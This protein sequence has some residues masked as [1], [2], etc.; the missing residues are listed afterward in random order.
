MKIFIVE[1]DH[2]HGTELWAASSQFVA[3]AIVKSVKPAIFKEREGDDEEDIWTLWKALEDWT[4][5]SGGSEYFRI[6][7]VPLIAQIE[8]AEKAKA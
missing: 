8:D 6:T 7:E 1:F 3:E 2:K 5:Y 4:E